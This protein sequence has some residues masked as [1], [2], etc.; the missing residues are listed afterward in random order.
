MNILEGYCPGEG[1]SQAKLAFIGEAPGQVEIDM[2]HPFVGPSG[3]ILNRNLAELGISRSEV[4]ITNIFKG[5]LP[6]NDFSKGNLREAMPQLTAELREV[7][8]NCLVLLGDNVLQAFTGKKGI[9]KWRGS[10]VQTKIGIKA[11]CAN[12]P[13]AMLYD[14]FKPY[15]EL[16][17]RKDLAKALRESLSRRFIL[18]P[19]NIKICNSPVEMRS[20]IQQNAGPYCSVDIESFH[21]VPICVGFGFSKSSAMVLPLWQTAMGFELTDM[22]MREIARCW[23]M[24]DKVLRTTKIIGHNFTFDQEKLECLGFEFPNIFIDTMH[25]SHTLEPE[26]PKGLDFVTS[27]YTDVPFYKYEGKQFNPKYDKIEDY[28]NYCGKDVYST[29]T[30]AMNMWDLLKEEGLESF[31]FD[32]VMRCYPEYHRMRQVGVNIDQHKREELRLKYQNW[33]NKTQYALEKD[34]GHPL[35]VKSNPQVKTTLYDELRIPKRAGTGENILVDLLVTN[36]IRDRTKREVVKNVLLA[37]KLRDNITRYLTSKPD[38]DG[39]MKTG[40][41]LTGTN[42]GRSATSLLDPPMRPYKIG[43][44]L[45]GVT[46]HG[47]VG[48][49]IREQFVPDPGHCFLEVDQKQAEARVVALLSKD[50]ELLSKFDDPDFDMHKYTASLIFDIPEEKIGRKDPERQMGKTVRHAGNYDMGE[51]RL[52]QTVQSAAFSY[53]K[54]ELLSPYKANKV[55]TAFHEACPQI[56][57][58]FHEEVKEALYED[59]TMFS[60]QGRKRI[61]YGPLVDKSFKEAYSFLPQ[62]TVSDHTKKVM[63]EFHAIRPDIPILLEAHDGLTFSVPIDEVKSVAK[64]VMGLFSQPISFKNCT[65]ERD[66]DLVIPAE[67]SVGYENWKDMKELD[68]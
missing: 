64:L 27:M 41:K 30:S 15:T 44:S 49:D 39:R 31:F 63:F 18:P 6:E 32:F 33:L 2:G 24:L 66:F 17:F 52:I 23:K 53:G 50:Y 60:P 36:S 28:F 38:F 58:V 57:G 10:L 59:R 54:L 43:I 35:N 40:Y 12:H 48:S 21:S 9:T 45:H 1:D 67:A 13:A 42:T 3:D 62:A 61:F 37:R 19:S 16:I 51:Y 29:Y 14:D 11:V 20:W 25:M 34:V 4:W 26:L 47:D 8:P 56:R 5:K 65:L 7:N 68:L 46:K 55:L 22:P